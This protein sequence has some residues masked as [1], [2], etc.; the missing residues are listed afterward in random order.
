MTILISSDYREY[1]H[2]AQTLIDYF[3]KSFGQIYGKHFISHNIHSMIHMYDD[4]IQFGC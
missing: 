4:Y 3:V 1:I 2:Y